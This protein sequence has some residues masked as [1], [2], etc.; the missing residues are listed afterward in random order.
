[1]DIRTA[2]QQGCRLLEDGGVSAPRLTAEV[3][4]A[5]ALSRERPYLYSHPED[6]LDG[7]AWLHYGRYLHERLRGTP[8]QYITHCQEFFGREFLVTDA[9]FIPRP[10]TEHVV[11]TAVR[12]APP[13]ARIVDVGCGSGAIAATLDLELK[14]AFVCATDI[15]LAALAVARE[16]ARR[17]NARVAFVACD[18][19]SAIADH[20][21]D[22][23]VSNPPYIPI[24]EQ[25]GLPREVRDHEPSTALFA[26]PGG[27]DVYARLVPEA[28]RLLRP[29]GAIVFELGYRQV[30]AVRAM[31]GARWT[32]VEVVSDLAGLPRVLAARL[33]A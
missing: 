7:Q 2:L 18:L 24:E 1:M 10:E 25:P 5:H 29:G 19:A 11:E 32:E 21:L 27:L 3:L 31:L 17:L 15:S 6:E 23:V 28:A 22:L 26:G 20:S 14:D 30:D 12:L 4:L 16:N 33:P 9:V 8:T 13:D